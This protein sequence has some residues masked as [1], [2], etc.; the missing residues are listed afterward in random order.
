MKQFV[1]ELLVDAETKK[2]KGRLVDPR[3]LRARWVV[4]PGDSEEM[5]TMEIAFTRKPRGYSISFPT[6][7]PVPKRS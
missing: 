1:V 5:C 2:I 7:L 4:A 6:A 3:L